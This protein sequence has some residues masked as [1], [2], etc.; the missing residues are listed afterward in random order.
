MVASAATGKRDSRAFATTVIVRAGE[1]LF[2]I[3]RKHGTTVAA[4]ERQNK[5]RAKDLR[6]GMRLQ[7][8]STNGNDPTAQGLAKDIQ[9]YIVRRGDTLSEIARRFDVALDDL[10]RDNPVQPENLRPGQT[11][12]IQLAQSEG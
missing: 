6:P 5:V 11:L 2:G 10:L 9:R 8:A 7:L 4:L 3:A 12:T 1:T